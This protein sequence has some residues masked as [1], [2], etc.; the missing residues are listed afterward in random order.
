MVASHRVA[1]VT[2]TM[3]V[4]PVKHLFLFAAMAVVWL[5]PPATAAQDADYTALL[6]RYVTG[7]LGK[8]VTELAAWPKA[9]VENAVRGLDRRDSAVL[10]TAV[11]LH[12]DAAYAA[13]SDRAAA[14]HLE[15]AESLLKLASGDKPRFA[16]RWH[17]WAAILHG[18]RG[19]YAQARRHISSGLN[20]DRKNVDAFIASGVLQERSLRNVEHNLRGDWVIR[21][22]RSRWE[23]RLNAAATAYRAALR[24]DPNSAEAHLRLGWVL[25]LNHSPRHAR[26]ELQWVT[27]NVRRTDLLYLAHLFLGALLERDQR[28]DEASSEYALAHA[29]APNQASFIAL[30]QLEL[31]QGRDQNGQALAVEFAA[32]SARQ[33]EDPWRSY[34]WGITGGELV[35]WLHAEAGVR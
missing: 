26:E 14:L 11:M 30:M 17:G 31:A 25:Y 2:G 7:D 35:E 13:M 33:N 20:L 18:M 10:R 6:G 23:A 24:N 3:S 12:T 21:G 27:T 1:P 32:R 34:T 22:D 5:P 4:W 16:A 29:A 8:P 19:N 9:R 28:F 15:I